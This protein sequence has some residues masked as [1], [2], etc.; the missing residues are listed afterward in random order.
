YQFASRHYG[1][2]LLVSLTVGLMNLGWLLP[3]AMWVALGGGAGRM[4]T[5]IAS[6]P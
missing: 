1:S 2:H 5:V 3:V 4:W 6:V